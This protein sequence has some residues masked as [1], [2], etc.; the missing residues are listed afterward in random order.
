MPAC[1]LIDE[2]WTETKIVLQDS[3]PISF[4]LPIDYASFTQQTIS[5]HLH[6]GNYLDIIITIVYSLHKYD[7]MSKPWLT[8]VPTRLHS[9]L[10]TIKQFIVP[11]V[12]FFTPSTIILVSNLSFVALAHDFPN[13]VFMAHVSLIPPPPDSATNPEIPEVR[14]IIKEDFLMSSLQ[15]CPTIYLQNVVAV[16]DPYADPLRTLSFAFHGIA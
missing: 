5:I 4:L 7:I 14:H 9:S 8:G 12:G 3:T 11:V 15:N 1:I 6:C 13:I 16:Y 10:P 2:V